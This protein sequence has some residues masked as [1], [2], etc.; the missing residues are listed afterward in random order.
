MFFQGA[1]GA[2]GERGATGN[3]GIPVSLVTLSYDIYD[4]SL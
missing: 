1:P 3:D 2:Q 4:I